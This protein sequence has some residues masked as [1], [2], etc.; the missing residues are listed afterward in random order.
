MVKI[1]EKHL[2]YVLKALVKIKAIKLM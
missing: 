1:S 2:I